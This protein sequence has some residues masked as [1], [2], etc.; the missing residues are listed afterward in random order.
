MGEGGALLV[1]EAASRARRRGAQVHG[2]VLGFGAS[3]DAFNPVMP[4]TDP[5]PAAQAI[6]AALADARINPDDIDYINPH[7]TSTQL[8]DVFETRAL[9]R[10]LGAA[11]RTIPVSGTKSM[12][13]HLLSAASAI[14]AVVCLTALRHQAIPPTLNLDDVDPECDLC[15]VPHQAQE[16]RVDIALSNSFGFGGSNTALLLRRV[17]WTRKRSCPNS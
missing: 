1:L 14:E 6:Q 12:T 10:A 2:E 9:H 13:G 4:S 8:G 16:R 17:A 5:G 3:S 11:V 7:A 15:H